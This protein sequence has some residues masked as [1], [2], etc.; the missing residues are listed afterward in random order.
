MPPSFANP[1]ASRGKGTYHNRLWRVSNARSLYLPQGRD[2][3]HEASLL[4]P[5]PADGP[6]GPGLDD[7]PHAEPCVPD[8]LPRAVLHRP[9]D[10]PLGLHPASPLQRHPPPPAAGRGA[11]YCAG[12]EPFR[13]LREEARGHLILALAPARAQ[14]RVGEGERPPGARDP[15]V[16][17]PPLLLEVLFVQR[18]GVRERPLL[19]PNYEDV[20]ELQALRVVER[21]QR[22]PAPLAREGVLL[23]VERLLLQEA[24][25]RGLRFDALV[26]AGCVYKLLQVLQARLGLDRVLRH[27]LSP[28]A[29]L[30]EDGPDQLRGAHLLRGNPPALEEITHR[31]A[32]LLRGPR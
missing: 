24:G 2:L 7:F 29:R 28:V 15:D 32:R 17:E 14:L 22:H 27:E 3:R 26:L 1:S 21:H 11:G 20:V 25:K 16:G 12:L 4:S 19:H 6:A 5:E 23:R 10:G 13:Y 31:A 18:A 9:G 8:L 30:V